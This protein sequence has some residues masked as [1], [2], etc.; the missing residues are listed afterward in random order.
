MAGNRQDLQLGNEWCMLQEKNK[1]M[2]DKK[3]K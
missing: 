3:N 1:Y 2:E